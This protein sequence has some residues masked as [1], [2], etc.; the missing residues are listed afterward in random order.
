MEMAP[1]PT[2][3]TPDRIAVFLAATSGTAPEL[4]ASLTELII[5]TVAAKGM[6]AVGS[7]EF[8]TALGASEAEALACGLDPLCLQRAGTRLGVPQVLFG[9][10]GASGDS[11]VVTL[12]LVSAETGEV[13]G[14]ASETVPGGAEGL[15]RA[16]PEITAKAFE[17]IV[18]EAVPVDPVVV[19]KSKKRNFLLAG[20]ASGV[21]LAVLGAAGLTIGLSARPIPRDM[22]MAHAEMVR[23]RRQVLRTTSIGLFIGAGALAAAT[24]V[25]FIV[26][27]VKETTSEGPA[28]ATDAVGPGG[29]TL[30]RW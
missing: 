1:E 21:T 24:V 10:V 8:R 4:A 19:V 22:G 15:L 18:T 12:N 20:I 25:L 3:A 11:H 7:A 23:D 27:P 29:V 9:T 5:A 26:A 14:R 13:V 16:I 17:P 2:R 30:L 28:P 6:T